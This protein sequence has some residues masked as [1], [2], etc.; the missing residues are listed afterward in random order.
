MKYQVLANLEGETIGKLIGYC[1]FLKSEAL[2]LVELSKG[3]VLLRGKICEIKE[4]FDYE[5][6]VMKDL[7]DQKAVKDKQS[8]L[9]STINTDKSIKKYENFAIFQPREV[10]YNFLTVTKCSFF[11]FTNEKEISSLLTESRA[12]IRTSYYGNRK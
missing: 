8:A 3:G 6:F 11:A 1:E 4:G 10:P 7:S 2:A 5:G 9:E 12:S